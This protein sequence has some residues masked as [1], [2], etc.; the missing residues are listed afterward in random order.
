M[1]IETTPKEGIEAS[2]AQTAATL[3][4]IE[5]ELAQHPDK[6]MKKEILRDKRSYSK[7]KAQFKRLQFLMS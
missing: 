5:D 7:V 1:Y 6:E 3:K 2:F 4:A